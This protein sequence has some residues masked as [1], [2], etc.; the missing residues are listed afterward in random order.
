MQ[1]VNSI[2]LHN[3]I[4]TS[5]IDFTFSRLIKNVHFHFEKGTLLSLEAKRERERER[6]RKKES[7]LVLIRERSYNE[8]SGIQVLS[9]LVAVLVPSHF[10]NRQ[11]Q[12]IQNLSFIKSFLL[13]F[14]VFLWKEDL[15]FFVSI[16]HRWIFLCFV[17]IDPV[18]LIHYTLSRQ[19]TLIT[20]MKLSLGGFVEFTIRESLFPL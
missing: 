1:K 20:G 18:P 7:Q 19:Y 2:N 4:F 9:G 8:I 10:D 17:S 5:S 13:F 12:G 16:P 14:V 15:C 3:K 6:E 11:I